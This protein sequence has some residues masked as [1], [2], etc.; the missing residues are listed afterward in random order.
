MIIVVDL[1]YVEDVVQPANRSI[2][3]R[4]L[5]RALS[6]AITINSLVMNSSL[7][8][9]QPSLLDYWLYYLCLSFSDCL[10]Y[11]L[12]DVSDGAVLWLN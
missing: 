4:I 12:L 5:F 10:C 8:K 6:S 2:E 11:L 3:A 1:H 9:S 7:Y